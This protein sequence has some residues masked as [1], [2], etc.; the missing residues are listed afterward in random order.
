MNSKI[1][2]ILISIFLCAF[3]TNLFIIF[4]QHKK[5]KFFLEGT[6]L[7]EKMR[8]ENIL[9]KEGFFQSYNYENTFIDYSAYVSNA[10][11]ETIKLQDLLSDKNCLILFMRVGSCRDCMYDNIE[12]VK[13]LKKKNV[14]VL[15]GV[16]GL[17][18]REF[19]SFINQ[20]E[21]ENMAYRLPDNFFPQFEVN[22]VV[23]FVVGENL[24]SKYFYAPSL[25][26]PD[27]T[28]EYFNIIEILVDLKSM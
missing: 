26:F 9:L 21:L 14:N 17:T 1:R 13:D 10:N 4:Y 8:V 19:K 16:E 15:I 23:Y 6:Q 3:I 20:Y 27:L 28:K 24:K 12:F 11:D 18:V 5:I 7:V 22:P 2:I 25:V